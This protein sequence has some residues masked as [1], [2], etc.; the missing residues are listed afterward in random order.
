MNFEELKEV[1]SKGNIMVDFYATWCGPCKM[2]MPTV[3]S[4]IEDG[5][6]VIKV[7]IDE[8]PEVKDEYGIMSVPTFIMFKDGEPTKRVTGFQPKELLVDMLEL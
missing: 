4:L 7:D 6:T 3:Q 5:H 8:I 2:M 1:L